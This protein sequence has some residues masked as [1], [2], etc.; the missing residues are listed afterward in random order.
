MPLFLQDDEDWSLHVSAFLHP[1]CVPQRYNVGHQ[2]QAVVNPAY[3]YSPLALAVAPDVGLGGMVVSCNP[4]PLSS[5]AQ[6]AGWPGMA[7]GEEL[8]LDL[9]GRRD[10][11]CSAP[12]GKGTDGSTIC[13][14]V[15]GGSACV[16]LSPSY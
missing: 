16:C 4:L 1:N 5:P 2:K 11:S 8:W 14:A 10:A 3:T 15:S 6:L 7:R 9:A 13:C 12:Q